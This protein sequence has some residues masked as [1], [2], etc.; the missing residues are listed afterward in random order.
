[1]III[2]DT[3]HAMSALRRMAQ[4]NKEYEEFADD[5]AQEVIEHAQLLPK[6]EDRL[7]ALIWQIRMGKFNIDL[8]ASIDIDPSYARAVEQLCETIFDQLYS[9][10][11]YLP[12]GLLPYHLYLP[13]VKYP[14]SLNDVLLMRVRELTHELE[15]GAATL[16]KSRDRRFERPD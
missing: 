9:L 15:H 13:H 2:L 8:G 5:I 12:D 10:K 16:S 7:D 3:A 6:A 11:L 4:Q 14:Q 1:M